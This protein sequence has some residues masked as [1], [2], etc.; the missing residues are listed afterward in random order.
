MA[1]NGRRL[2][3]TLPWSALLKVIAAVALVAILLH[4]WYI[5]TLILIA[6]IV[7]VGLYPA[8]VWLEQRG[9]SRTM[10]ASVV[11]FGLVA[12]IIAFLG[13]TWS[14]IVGQGQD[15]APQLRRTRCTRH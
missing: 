8:V 15:V 1:E 6:I 9:W 12:L 14:S 11:G 10:A 7:A 13:F 5:L 3:L 2:S 4:I